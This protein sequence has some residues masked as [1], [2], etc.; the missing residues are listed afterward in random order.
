M[1]SNLR[2]THRSRLETM[3]AIEI[4]YQRK[5]LALSN[6]RIQALKKLLTDVD[7][8]HVGGLS[9]TMLQDFLEGDEIPVTT[10][11]STVKAS[12][13]SA[14]KKPEKKKKSKKTSPPTKSGKLVSGKLVPSLKEALQIVTRNKQ[15]TPMEAYKILKAKGW[16]PTSKDPLGY[17]RFTL[18]DEKNIFMRVEGQRGVYELDPT[19]PY[20]NGKFP[21][22]NPKV[23]KSSHAENDTQLE[24]APLK[25]SPRVVAAPLPPGGGSEPPP[26]ITDEDS[27][28]TVTEILDG[29]IPLD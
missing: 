13:T 5:L 17:I 16:L 28:A 1:P 19:N 8:L 15:I 9:E 10:S 26:V 23:S 18:S 24:E 11:S 27:R 12:Q 2:D 14:T 22:R 6:Q 25:S 21:T 29:T 20:Y 4:E 7:A 3:L